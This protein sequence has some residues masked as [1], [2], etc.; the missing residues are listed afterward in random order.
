ME[1]HEIRFYR[2]NL[3]AELFGSDGDFNRRGSAR[4]AIGDV[5]VPSGQ[6]CKFTGL[7]P[8]GA[9]KIT[10]R[11]ARGS[12]GKDE[13]VERIGG[14]SDE[15]TTGHNQGGAEVTVGFLF[16]P[17]RESTRGGGGSESN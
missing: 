14:E 12:F 1:F 7:A 17:L 8:T 10:E 4:G 16:H 5:G 2:R 15:G 3:S 6:R 13:L 9:R 11:L